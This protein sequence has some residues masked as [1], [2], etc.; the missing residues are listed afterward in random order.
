MYKPSWQDIVLQNVLY[1]PEA[2]H[3][4]ISIG[5]LDEG[6]FDTTFG[7]GKAHIRKGER[8]YGIGNRHN[9]QYWLDLKIS[10]PSLNAISRKDK[11]LDLWH[12]RYG[13]LGYDAL[14]KLANAKNERVKGLHA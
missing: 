6:G 13:H 12:Q 8:C 7:S 9:G 14:E 3:R 4:Y 5:K 2:A 11:P 10:P 1:A